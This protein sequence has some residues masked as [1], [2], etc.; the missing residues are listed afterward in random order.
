[1]PEWAVAKKH[2]L[3]KYDKNVEHNEAS[4]ISILDRTDAKFITHLIW[5]DL[6]WF[7]LKIHLL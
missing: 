5:L 6:K 4:S 7:T 3:K 1:M 2:I